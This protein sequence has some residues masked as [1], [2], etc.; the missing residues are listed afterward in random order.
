MDEDLL[1]VPVESVGIHRTAEGTRREAP[2]RAGCRGQHQFA[3]GDHGG[4]LSGRRHPGNPDSIIWPA[5]FLA[6][7]G[8]TTGGWQ[9]WH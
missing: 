4:R 5:G 3:L 9:S 1:I 7:S 6:H 2:H 8:T